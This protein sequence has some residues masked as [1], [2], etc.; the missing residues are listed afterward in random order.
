MQNNTQNEERVRPRLASANE[1]KGKKTAKKPSD[2]RKKRLTA[3]IAL[4]AVLAC[5]I[6]GYFAV[7][8][9][10]PVEEP[11]PATTSANTI[12]QTIEGRKK[13][14]VAKVT[15]YWD[16]EK[17]YT[18]VS[19]L[20]AKAEAAEKASGEVQEEIPAGEA[21]EAISADQ[22]G[23]SVA[24][25]IKDTLDN[26]TG[27]MNIGAKLNPDEETED[28]VPLPTELPDPD[29]IIPAAEP[30]P[31]D[32]ASLPDYQVEGMPWFQ[33]KTSQ[34]NNM[35]VYGFTMTASRVIEENAED[36]AVYGLDK[37]Q[38]QAV[39]EYHDGTTMTINVGNK[40][41]AGNYYYVTLDDSRTV[42]MVHGNI[43]SYNHYALESL[44]QMP[45]LDTF[46]VDNYGADW[47]LIEQRGK[48]TIEMV[49]EETNGETTSISSWMMIQP[50]RYG[51]STDRSSEIEKGIA[52]IALTGFAGYA[53]DEP[54]LAGYGLTDP[55][56]HVAMT[57][58]QENSCD[59]VIGDLV[60]GGDSLRYVTIDDSGIV[61]TLDTSLLSFLSDARV[62]YVVDQFANLVYIKRVNGFEITTPDT[63]YTA[64]VEH[65]EETNDKGETKEK[66][67]FIYEGEPA[68]EDI[69]RD[70]YQVVIGTLFDKR[71]E[72]ANEWHLEGDAE[73]TVTYHL[74]YTDEPYVVE[75]VSY[76]RDYY[77]IRKEG[78]T[79]FL[80][81]KEKVQNVI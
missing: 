11:E 40:I 46:D 57:D 75:Y 21:A 33:L 76:D 77:A 47:V 1:L 25:S 8:A 50:V 36:M 65:Y 38:V 70:F 74:T 24:D 72:D 79:L 68:E 67:R 71:I 49:M 29:P 12:T 55:Y 27:V 43:Y 14:D 19:N 44:Y 30:D 13:Q 51:L 61:Y 16:G 62:S 32:I 5:I 28:A 63:V 26:V 3:I 41:P 34:A 2:I 81:R 80:I 18:I 15:V 78:V 73:V 10:K 54:S 56:A 35:I 39:F 66:E 52:G 45:T 59:F 6:G 9:L 42:Y 58:S 4:T 48:E 64:V 20:Q 17:Q 31:V 7:Q 37:P 69:F 23:S 53:P 60:E 22:S